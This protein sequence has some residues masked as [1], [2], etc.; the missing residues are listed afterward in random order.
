MRNTE[1]ENSIPSIHPDDVCLEN[2]VTKSRSNESDNSAVDNSI[3]NFSFSGQKILIIRRTR[4]IHVFRHKLLQSILI[5][6]GLYL[7]DLTDPLL[8]SD[9]TSFLH[10][11]SNESVI[12]VI[13]S[14]NSAQTN[15]SKNP[16]KLRHYTSTIPKAQYCY[17][18]FWCYFEF[19][20][21][22]RHQRLFSTYVLVRKKLR[23]YGSSDMSWL[24]DDY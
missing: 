18:K 17:I 4:K 14:G 2:I 3:M 13:S 11:C 6:R 1:K 10:A 24:D 15:N 5:T 8:E 12:A 9:L 7:E 22:A 16:E 23:V 19:L 21:V 20:I